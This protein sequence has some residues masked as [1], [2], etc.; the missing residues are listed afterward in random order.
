MEAFLAFDDEAPASSI[1]KVLFRV[2]DVIDKIQ[3]IASAVRDKHVPF[4]AEGTTLR[5]SKHVEA[6]RE[7]T[8]GGATDFSV[9]PTTFA[10]QY[11]TWKK[12]VLEQFPG[13]Y[14]ERS[15]VEFDTDGGHNGSTYQ[16]SLEDFCKAC[17]VENG[18]VT[19]FGSWLDQDCASK[20]AKII[21]SMPA[22]LALQVPSPGTEGSNKIYRRAF[23]AW[24]SVLRKPPPM[25]VTVSAGNV[26]SFESHRERKFNAIEVLAIDFVGDKSAITANMKFGPPD[27]SNENNM[28]SVIEDVPSG[29]ELI[30]Y[31]VSRHASAA[32]LSA[33]MDISVDSQPSQSTQGTKKALVKAGY[34]SLSGNSIAYTWLKVLSKQDD[35]AVLWAPIM[36]TSLA[37]RLEDEVSFRFNIA[38]PSGRTSYLGRKKTVADRASIN[39]EH[40]PDPPMNPIII[41]IRPTSGQNGL[42]APTRGCGARGPAGRF[43]GSARICGFGV[44]PP[45]PFCGARGGQRGGRSSI[46]FH[47]AR[48]GPR[49]GR[50]FP[51]T[52]PT[53]GRIQRKRRRY[54]HSLKLEQRRDRAK[55]L[56]ALNVPVSSCTPDA[57]STYDDR[58]L[59][60]IQEISHARQKICRD[61]STVYQCDMCHCVL[62]KDESRFHCFDCDDFD[63]CFACRKRHISPPVA[64]RIVDVSNLEDNGAQAS[65]SQQNEDAL[66]SF[67][68]NSSPAKYSTIDAARSN[69]TFP[70]V[71]RTI[72]WC[73][74]RMQRFLLSLLDWW[75]LFRSS[76]YFGDRLPSSLSEELEQKIR[77]CTSNNNDDVPLSQLLETVTIVID[78]LRRA[79]QNLKA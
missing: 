2:G 42:R 23:S 25:K 66:V 46:P 39:P 65:N 36:A 43:G 26:D 76:L 68:L 53:F 1:H 28:K 8:S 13:T 21:G 47:A 33:Q 37:T 34:E 31:M 50:S 45:K 78:S 22:Q 3:S 57:V 12:E 49:G 79:Q 54:I 61:P 48:G 72:E 5:I 62:N 7:I 44:R 56:D 19:G 77:D 60:S 32:Q 17:K 64:H 29:S 52:A 58:M 9:G 11:R 70:K 4:D 51:V 67:L 35:A 41:Q 59:Q 14:S 16:K 55:W 63:A 18:V 30:L 74:R 73:H 27:V 6:I 69:A 75:P 71:D 40:Q 10:Q 20:V 15:F 24:I 38:S